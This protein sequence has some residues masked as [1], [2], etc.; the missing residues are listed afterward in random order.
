[1]KQSQNQ[2]S[3]QSNPDF[4]PLNPVPNPPEWPPLIQVPSFPAVRS[5]A[6][7][8]SD[9]PDASCSKNQSCPATFLITASNQ[10]FG[11]GMASDMFPTLTS[12]NSS[13]IAELILGTKA[14]LQD[15]YLSDP[16]FTEEIDLYYL[17]PKCK[18]GSFVSV[19]IKTK[20][21]ESICM[22]SLTLWRNSSSEV[23][24]AIFEG[25]ARVNTEKKPFDFAGAY[26]FLNSN[27]NI[28]NVTVW[29]Q[30]NA[31]PST[32][33]A[34]LT[35]V[36]QVVNLVSNA[37]LRFLN[38]AG[39]KILLEFIKDMPT[40][41]YMN[42]P[43]FVAMMS[44]L[45]FIWIVVWLF[46]VIL[47][48]LVYEKQHKLRMMMKM[49]GLGDRAY[50]T[51]SYGYF[52]IISA[53]YMLCFVAFGSILR[54]AFFT[55]NAYSI[56]FVFYFVYVNLQVSMAFLASTI[57]SNVKTAAVVG[58][59][60]VFVTGLL[61]NFLFVRVL[62]EPSFPRKWVIVLELFPG[63][64]LF[65]GLYE[66]QQYAF[67]GSVVG[68]GG[69]QWQDLND[70]ENGMKE[71]II[72][73]FVE[74]LVTLFLAYYADRALFSGSCMRKPS[75]SATK[76]SA[77][78][79]GTQVP[80]HRENPDVAEER[81]KVKQLMLESPENHAI[82]CDN[83]RKVYPARDGNPPKIA[84]KGMYL[85]LPQTGCFGLLGPN[86]AGK[87]SFISMM[88]GLTQPTSGT[89]FVNGLDLRTSMDEIYSMMGVCPQ[90]DLLWET[91]TAREHL[92]FYGRLKN[93]G[94]AALKEAVEASLKNANLFH[95]GVADKP[96]GKYS[97][98]M[99]RRLS[100]AISLIGDPKVVYMD[101]PSTGLDPAS[102]NNLWNLVRLA[103][104]DRAI[105]LTTHSME[106]AEALCDRLGIFVDGSLQCIADA[107]ELKARYGG[108]LVLTITTTPEHDAEVED[109]VRYLSPNAHK[110]YHLAGTQKFE[111]P[112]HDLRIADVF[113]AVEIAK[114]R[115]PIH[116]WGLS[117]TS[118]EDVFIKV[119]MATASSSV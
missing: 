29:Y 106:E 37:Y 25:N 53:I 15:N 113:E 12:V 105:V 68:N 89:V 79:N 50:W 59:L 111:L 72:I 16:A 7:P 63:F 64:L 108:S 32:G 78:R 69:M 56:Q 67:E 84:V 47:Q 99:K 17:Q 42:Q 96:A 45:L 97:G 34:S 116:A 76:P 75:T 80:S 115:L 91:L 2:Q 18:E 24:N 82:V 4:K 71:V 85:A 112:K 35:R 98:G 73:M 33:G 94:G 14:S 6:L 54:L 41:A 52:A 55:M 11:L 86:G 9:L 46:P 87:T 26:D 93:L 13:D 49:H 81:E 43:N 117:D 66:L 28:F 104:Q 1:M 100:V 3:E 8:F 21:F 60:L 77:Q 5:K 83:L 103:K 62:Q 74:W 58:Y 101:E 95:G 107:R 70:P 44:T 39:T 31:L 23:N 30:T 109:M 40:H 65:R 119:A 19:P 51:I 114:T 48:A 110:T 61:G 57:F 92:L 20:T 36:E 38:G 102:R 118:L 10:S 22:Q 27:S 90:Y 88:I